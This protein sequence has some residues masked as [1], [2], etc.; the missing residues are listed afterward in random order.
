MI[1]C[2]NFQCDIYISGEG[3]SRALNYLSYDLGCG[4]L[5][6]N[7]FQQLVPFAVVL[8]NDTRLFPFL[9]SISNLILKYLGLAVLKL[10]KCVLIIVFM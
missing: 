5:F 9:I 8:F 2:V 7:V 6:V 1:S 10:R 4:L 3:S